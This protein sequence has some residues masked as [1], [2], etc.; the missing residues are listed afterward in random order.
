MR[1]EAHL[2]TA[3]TLRGW[4]LPEPGSDKESRGRVLVVGGSEQTPGAVL[5]AGEAA[6][7]AGGGKLQMATAETATAALAVAVPEGRVLPLE[8][9]ADGSLAAAA[10]PAVLRA[11][12]SAGVVLLGPGLVDLDSSVALMEQVVP[13]LDTAVVVDAL[14][15]AFVTAHADGLRH[16]SGRCVLTVNPTE[17]ARVLDRDDDEVSTDQVQATRD[18]AVR[19]GVVVLCGGTV[20]TV[21]TPE[22]DAWLV[23]EGGPGLGVSGSG[24]V[25]AGIVA[26]LLARGADPAQAAVWGAALHG[27][28]GERLA[29]TTGPIGFL[30]RELPG[31]LPAIV[32]ELTR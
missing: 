8:S 27:R 17:L 18:A 2:V 14:A 21:A 32:A 12:E 30:A 29:V 15:S 26:G 9:T 6:L 24:D 4:S 31:E 20:K 3:E 5:L 7:R 23:R 10:A 28:A 19:S 13:R 22:G 1:A 11:A 16:L 25:Q